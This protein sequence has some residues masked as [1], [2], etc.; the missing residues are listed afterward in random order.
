VGKLQDA[1]SHDLEIKGVKAVRLGLPGYDLWLPHIESFLQ[2]PIIT[3]DEAET[4]RIIQRVPVWPSELNLEV[5]PPEA[6]LEKTAMSFSKGCYI[7]QEV[8]SRIKTTGKMPRELVAWQ[9]LDVATKD[10]LPGAILRLAERDVGTI[11]SV[12]RHPINGV[13]VGLAFIRHGTA[14]V[15]SEL[16]VGGGLSSITQRVQLSALLNP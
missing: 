13:L 10:V 9:A 12:A 8:L 6:G 14:Q 2:Q 3:A 7:G 16:L 4:L 1:K 5:F 11:T 15:H